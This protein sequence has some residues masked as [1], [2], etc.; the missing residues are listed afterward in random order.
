MDLAVLVI[1][2]MKMVTFNAMKAMVTDLDW[3]EFTA[4]CIKD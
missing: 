4:D 3:G 2:S 1:I